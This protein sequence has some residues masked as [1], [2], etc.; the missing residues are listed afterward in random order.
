[1]VVYAKPFCPGCPYRA[2]PG[3]VTKVDSEKKT[4][5]MRPEISKLWLKPRPAAGEEWEV[6]RMKK[7]LSRA[8]VMSWEQ[9]DHMITT[10][11]SEDEV[12][13]DKP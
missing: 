9:F 7:T 4:V 13:E 12:R 8:K 6:D 11:L 5:T 3:V 10:D 2:F 1:M